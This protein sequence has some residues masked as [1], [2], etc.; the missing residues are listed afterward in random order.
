MNKKSLVTNR[1]MLEMIAKG[2]GVG[3]GVGGI[4]ALLGEMSRR[5]ERKKLDE[6]RKRKSI[7]VVIPSIKEAKHKIEGPEIKEFKASYKGQFRD[8]GKFSESLS[9]KS[10]DSGQRYG[11]GMIAG[12]A[13]AYLGYKGITDLVDRLRKAKLKNEIKEEKK[14]YVENI[15][16]MNKD[17]SNDLAP[18]WTSLPADIIHSVPNLLPSKGSTS[19]KLVGLYYALLGATALGTG[20]LTYKH[21]DNVVGKKLDKINKP[22][23]HTKLIVSDNFDD[24]EEDKDI[25]KKASNVCLAAITLKL[26]HDDNDIDLT[27]SMKKVASLEYDD[28]ITTLSEDTPLCDSILDTSFNKDGSFYSNFYKKAFIM[29]LTSW[30]MYKKT[31][32]QLNNIKDDIED[33]DSDGSESDAASDATN[34]A[35]NDAAK[36]EGPTDIIETPDGEKK[37]VITVT[38]PEILDVIPKDTL[39]ETETI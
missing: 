18:S 2:T 30:L 5:K 33:I 12:V 4:M 23:I 11:V 22:P 3:V 9:K 36:A 13:G 15:Y 25:R 7:R 10:M 28:M 17:A 39:K 34:D 35:T 26:A 20:A 29:P 38:D 6:E 8:K 16:N 31:T 27:D 1:D 19:D 14:K 24:D 37:V 32:N 21:L